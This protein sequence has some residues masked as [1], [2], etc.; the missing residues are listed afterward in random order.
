M[1]CS[2]HSCPLINYG[3]LITAAI[4]S[5]ESTNYTTETRTS[6]AVP[7]AHGGTVRYTA[8]AQILSAELIRVPGNSQC[9]L[10]V[11]SNY[12]RPSPVALLVSPRTVLLEAATE[13]P[14][15]EAASLLFYH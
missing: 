7:T 3:T 14:L 2:T 8:S 11:Y 4:N 6:Y 1:R 13:T 9:Q 15:A 5:L 12:I 10:A